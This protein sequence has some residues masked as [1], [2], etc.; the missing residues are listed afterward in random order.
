MNWT[1]IRSAI[2]A[3]CQVALT[4][5]EEPVDGACPLCG[6]AHVA[7]RTGPAVRIIGHGI[8]CVRCASH[9]APNLQHLVA[10]K[11]KELPRTRP[12]NPARRGGRQILNSTN[13]KE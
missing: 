5:E 9:V 6:A 4:W 1:Q 3:R 12:G 10:L 11:A 7:G 2:H 8:L 13:R